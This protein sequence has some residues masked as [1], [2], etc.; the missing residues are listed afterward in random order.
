M[1]RFSDYQDYNSLKYIS[2]RFDVNAM[3]NNGSY[4]LDYT[5]A[6]RHGPHGGVGTHALPA[7]RAQQLHR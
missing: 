2:W 5:S 6:M 3:L 4:L 7:L 1:S